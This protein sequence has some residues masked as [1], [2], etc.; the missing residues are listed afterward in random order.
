MRI[1]PEARGDDH[2]IVFVAGLP[3][4][5]LQADDHLGRFGSSVAR[6]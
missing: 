1:L 4:K 6:D 2:H 3:N 5:V